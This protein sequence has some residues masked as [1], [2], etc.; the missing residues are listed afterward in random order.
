MLVFLS[1]PLE[2]LL[3]YLK[4]FS[5]KYIQKFKKSLYEKDGC[6]VI[7]FHRIVCFGQLIHNTQM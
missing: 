2:I 4:L 1:F 6:E 7:I 5:M 3:D